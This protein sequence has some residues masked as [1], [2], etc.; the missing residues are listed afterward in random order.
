VSI[1]LEIGRESGRIHSFAAVRG[2]TG[3]AFTHRGGDLAKALAG[4]DDFAEGAVFVLG[5]NLIGFDAPHLE[6]AKPDL[7]LLKLPRV[8]TLRLNPLAFPRNPY[9]HLVKHYQ[10]GQLKRGRRND[11]EL[12]ARLTLEVFADQQR[13]LRE[14]APDLLTAWHWLASREATGSGIDAFFATVRRR[15][16]P[17]AEE[18]RAAVE[19]RLRGEACAGQGAKALEEAGRSGWPLAYAL[20]WLSVAGGNSVMPPWV[21]HQFPEA[22]ALVRRLRDTP[23]GEAGCAWCRERHDPCKE[24]KRWFGFDAYRPEPRHE[25][26][27]MQEAKG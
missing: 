4:L 14:A 9:H 7:R 24:L 15:A 16:R 11:P 6:A 21:R 5:H 18:A 26:R 2:D 27:S 1:D 10:D 12:D 23:C 22:G 25:G 20:A 19:G 8:D 3:Q 17:A 13:V